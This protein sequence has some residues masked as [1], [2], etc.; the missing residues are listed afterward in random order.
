MS[1]TTPSKVIDSFAGE[2]RFL[3]NFYPAPVWY[4]SVQYPTVEHAF[5]AAKT[6]DSAVQDK[7]RRAKTPGQAKG[8][9]RKVVLRADWE[10]VKVGVMKALVE[11]KFLE[12]KVL[13]AELLATGDAELCEGNWWNDKIWGMAK[14]FNGVWV[15]Q[16]LLGKILME[17]REGLRPK[18]V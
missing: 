12:N 5:Q 6:L 8:L 13:A 9:G 2:Y 7:I 16:N 10:T 1:A 15:G 11:A 14:D 18:K 3:S 17:V 4:G